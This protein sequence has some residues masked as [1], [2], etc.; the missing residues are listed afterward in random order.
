ME[1]SVQNLVQPVDVVSGLP[2]TFL[3][4]VA[5]RISIPVA[6]SSVSVAFAGDGKSRP[7]PSGHQWVL[8]TISRKATL[9]FRKI[10]CPA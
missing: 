6:G 10:R 2:D 3:I 7:A 1:N 5:D 9:V 4:P 8:P